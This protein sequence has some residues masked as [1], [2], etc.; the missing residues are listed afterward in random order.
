MK[1][2]KLKWKEMRGVYGV[3][4]DVIEGKDGFETEVRRWK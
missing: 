3:I 4:E 1:N 2:T